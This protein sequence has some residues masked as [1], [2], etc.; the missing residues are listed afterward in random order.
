MELETK[1][2][3]VI[4]P[5]ITPYAQ[6]SLDTESLKN[7]AGKAIDAGV[8]G[9][10]ILGA[11][12]EFQR[13]SSEEKKLVID[14]I[15]S[16]NKRKTKVIAGV[17]CDS[18]ENTVELARY[19]EDKGVDALLL[20]P[21]YQK[22]MSAIDYLQFFLAGIIKPNY[23]ITPVILYNNPE[24]SEGK[25]IPFRTVDQLRNWPGVIGIKDSSSQ[26][27]YFIK[28]LNFKSESFSILLGS[29]RLLRDCPYLNIDG[30]VSGTGNLEPELVMRL[31]AKRK[32]DD[33]NKIGE[34]LNE[35]SKF[36]SV[37]KGIK[38]FAY[39]MGI[40]KSNEMVSKKVSK[41]EL[42]Q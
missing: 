5:L 16:L 37:I 2:K 23:D 26:I 30:F 31:F 25:N 27:G 38:H 18:L 40:I 6:G 15:M 41:N 12:G 7:L 4:I 9:L 10:L 39:Q 35:Y 13:L 28:L 33:I 32:K 19:A 36:D 22:E 29:E 3:G 21:L 24:I 20:M 34:Y 8:D 11:T 42:L 1:L 14:T 17:T